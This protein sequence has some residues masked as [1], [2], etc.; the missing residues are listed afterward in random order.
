MQSEMVSEGKEQASNIKE[1]IYGQVIAKANHYMAVPDGNGGRRIIKDDSIR[2]YESSFKSQCTKYRGRQISGKFILH[3]DVYSTSM[4]FDLDN[5][6]KTILD[7][8]QYVRAITDDNLCVGIDAS[9]HIDRR[10]PRVTFWI[11]EL[12]PTLSLV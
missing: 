10:N 1:T 4:R 7:C 11:E 6:L 2:G 12:E 8:L 5:S 3:T 9:K